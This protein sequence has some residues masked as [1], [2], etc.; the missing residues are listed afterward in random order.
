MLLT[1]HWLRKET[2]RLADLALFL[3]SNVMLLCK[4]GLSRLGR[5]GCAGRGS[6]ALWRL[7]NSVRPC[8][9]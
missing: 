6:L 3:R 5:G 2:E 9:Y 8:L 4:F 1:V 7:R